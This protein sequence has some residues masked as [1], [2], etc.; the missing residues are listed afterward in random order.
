MKT[1]AKDNLLSDFESSISNVPLITGYSPSLWQESIIV[2]IKKRIQSTRVE[3]LH[4]LVLMEADLNFN[5]KLLGKIT[6]NHAETRKCIAPEQYRSR[7]NMM[8]VD[9]ALH[10]QLTYNIIRQHHIP[11]IL[12][13]N[14]AKSCYD[15]VLHSIA[16]LAY[17]RLGIDTPPVQCMLESIQNM[18]HHI[19]TNFGVSAFTL[20][21]TKYTH[22]FSGYTSR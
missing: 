17:Q 2:M 10:K 9:H 16:S 22:S 21:K 11:A 6:M 20:S 5:N 19:R 15:R 8:A 3:G 14:N 1:C 12:C 18:D 7:K 4:S 13:L